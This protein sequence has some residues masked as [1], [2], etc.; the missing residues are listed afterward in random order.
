[1]VTILNITYNSIFHFAT[2]VLIAIL[3]VLMFRYF[4]L[5]LKEKSYYPEQWANLLR[6]KK[7][8]TELIII[9]ENYDDKI[10]FYNFW[11]QIERLK[12]ENI[13]GDFAELG[14]YKGETAHIIHTLD[15]S[16]KLHLFDTFE[17]FKKEDLKEET[18]EAASYSSK[19]FADTDIK[20]V[21]ANIDG[22]NNIIV[23]KGYFPDTTKDLEIIKYAFVNIDADLYNPIKEGLN[24]F[25]P[26]LSPGGVIIIHDYNHK[27][28]GAVK[29]VNEF[30]AKIPENIIEVADK[31]GSVMF[32]RNK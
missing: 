29:A 14:V 18:G 23:H 17:G 4:I 8:S 19:N 28:E 12:R 6:K 9:E 10:R 20:K 13:S 15:K 31:N 2:A 5:S 32:I 25:Y 27:W 24:Y 1:M 11:F 21:L 30:A 16:R 7:I 3:A 22:G 26:L